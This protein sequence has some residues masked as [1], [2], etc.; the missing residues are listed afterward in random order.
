MPENEPVGRGR[1]FIDVRGLT[2]AGKPTPRPRSHFMLVVG[3]L[4][5]VLGLSWLIFPIM[6]FSAGDPDFWRFIVG[7]GQL[8]LGIGFIIGW[9][10]GRNRKPDSNQY[11]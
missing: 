10:R 5:L 4:W 9:A 3:L 1:R 11:P 8:V 2:E 7:L 6:E